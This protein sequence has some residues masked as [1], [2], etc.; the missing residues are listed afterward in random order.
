[1]IHQPAGP[2]NGLVPHV[3]GVRPPEGL[4]IPARRKRRRL[5]SLRLAVGAPGRGE[6]HHGWPW[7]WPCR[8]PSAGA[9]RSEREGV[10]SAFAVRSGRGLEKA[11]A[12]ANSRPRRDAR[13][14]VRDAAPRRVRPRQQQQQKPLPTFRSAVTLVPIDVRVVE[15]KTGKAV[16]DMR[17]EEFTVVEDGVKQ[18]VK[19]LSLQTF[20]TDAPDP[21]SKLQLKEEAISFEPQ[22]NR[23]FLIVL[24]RGK[25]LEP[26]KAMDALLRFVRE[27]LL[28]QRPG[29]GLRLQPRHHVLDRPRADR[30]R[31]RAV[32]EGARADRLRGRAADE[33]PGGHLRRE[34]DPE[35]A[36]G[37]D[38]QD[39]RRVWPARLAAGRAPARPPTSGS[40][41]TRSGRPTR[42]SRSRKRWQGRRWQRRPA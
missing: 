4:A 6:P 14:P 20:V 8:R 7:R 31:H 39:V 15:N 36:A 16:T 42:R 28:P 11:D 26:S 17:Q 18:E 40:R 9:L 21:G 33:R 1:M 19:H 34:A 25:L 12:H 32:Q 41:R 13:R 2:G 27:R 22:K 38:R 24:G 35:V 10:T 5:T 29:G 3:A 30:A 23:I 37:E